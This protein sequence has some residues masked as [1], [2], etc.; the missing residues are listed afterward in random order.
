[1]WAV[2][3]KSESPVGIA[4]T[5]EDILRICGIELKTELVESG[6]PQYP[7]DMHAVA[8]KSFVKGVWFEQKYIMKDE[9]SS[10]AWAN[11]FTP[12]TVPQRILDDIIHKLGKTYIIA[13]VDMRQHHYMGE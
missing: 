3:T 6:D 4:R 11:G 12:E 1:M 13:P 7:L 8:T 10:W 2:M 9:R 5:R